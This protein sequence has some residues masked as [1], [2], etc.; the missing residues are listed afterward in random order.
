M[1]R[2]GFLAFLGGAAAVA[3]DPEALLWTPKKLISIPKKLHKIGVTLN[4]RRPARFIGRGGVGYMPEPIVDACVPL[5]IT[6]NNNELWSEA[7]RNRHLEKLVESMRMNTKSMVEAYD[8]DF[9][10]DLL[11]A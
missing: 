1:T 9:R 4:I 6:F 2:R 7:D 3:T 8:R 11:D 5:F 10:Q